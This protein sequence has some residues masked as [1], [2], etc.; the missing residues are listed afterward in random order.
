[1]LAELHDLEQ[2]KLPMS[3]ALVDEI[4]RLQRKYEALARPEPVPEP[5]PDVEQRGRS[6][7]PNAVNRPYTASAGLRRLI[8]EGKV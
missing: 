2:K 3:K 7:G 6:L 8:D 4:N 1:M 5:Q